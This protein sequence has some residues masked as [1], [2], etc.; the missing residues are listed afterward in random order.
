VARAEAGRSSWRL[1]AGDASAQIDQ[2]E[3]DANSF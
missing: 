3:A 1:D 2:L